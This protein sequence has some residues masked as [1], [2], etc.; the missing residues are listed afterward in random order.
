MKRIKDSIIEYVLDRPRQR[1][2]VTETARQLHISKGYVSKTIY[3]MRKE[4]LVKGSFVNMADPYVRSLKVSINLH[5]IKTSGVILE[6][7]RL[8][9]SGA[10]L[11]GSWANGTNTEDSDIDIWLKTSDKIGALELSR[12]SKKVGEVL[13]VRPQIITLDSEHIK[14]LRKNNEVFYFTL[15]LSSIILVGDGLGQA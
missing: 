14:R 1:V 13:K 10:G 8:G 3:G 9:V 4:G 12:L 11:Y 5:R 2:R 6:I 7:R 15:A